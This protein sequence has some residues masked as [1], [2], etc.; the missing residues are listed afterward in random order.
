MALHQVVADV[1][2]TQ[3]PVKAVQRHHD[4]FLQLVRQNPEQWQIIEAVYGQV[5]FTLE[6]LHAPAQISRRGCW[7]CAATGSGVAC[8]RSSCAGQSW[9]WPALLMATQ[10]CRGSCSTRW[11]SPIFALGRR[12]AALQHYQGA[13][14]ARRLTRDRHGEAVT[15]NNIGQVYDAY[16]DKRQALAWQ[17]QARNYL[18]QGITL[19]NAGKVYADMG[20]RQ[21]ALEHFEQALTL[22]RAWA[23]TPAKLPPS[24]MIGKVYDDLGYKRLALETYVRAL[25]LF[26]RLGN[27]AGEASTLS[28]IGSVYR[29]AGAHKQAITCYK[30]ALEIAQQIGDKAAEA[31]TRNNIASIYWSDGDLQLALADFTQALELVRQLGSQGEEARTFSNIGSVYTELGDTPQALGYLEEARAV[32]HQLE[33]WGVRHEPSATSGSPTGLLARNNWPWPVLKMP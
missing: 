14:T 12:E 32:F 13:L 33:D 15:L 7:R 3:A 17:R 16:G 6:R 30:Q 2:R 26:R 23:T 21:L 22:Q 18:G 5:R 24:P 20:E 8:V 4:Y 25:F 27:R 29:S 31:T 10:N 9:H 19:V 11:G 28:N 1:A